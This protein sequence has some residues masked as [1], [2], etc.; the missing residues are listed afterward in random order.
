MGKNQF[1]PK[2]ADRVICDYLELPEQETLNYD[3]IFS[4]I[5]KIQET[6]HPKYNGYLF[7]FNL[8]KTNA[9][10]NLGD[11]TNGLEGYF[12]EYFYTPHHRIDA[13]RKCVFEW[14]IW[15]KNINP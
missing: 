6:Y 11:N 15:Y 13:I 12:S 3:L 8:N 14:I 7:C 1:N 2:K 10:I 4:A 5:D 9:W